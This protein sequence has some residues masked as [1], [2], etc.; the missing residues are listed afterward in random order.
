[1]ISARE[2]QAWVQVDI[3]QVV[4][5]ARNGGYALTREDAEEVLRLWGFTNCGGDVWLCSARAVAF[6]QD[7]E[8]KC[9]RVLGRGP[10][11]C[12]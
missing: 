1:M 6:L 2:R 3:D 4:K 9:Q 12:N 8:I 11:C 10:L 7:N 5:N